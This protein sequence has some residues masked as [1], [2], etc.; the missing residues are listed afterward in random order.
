[1]DWKFVTQN[2]LY[3]IPAIL[4]FTVLIGG[5]KTYP[6]DWDYHLSGNTFGDGALDAYPPLS[7]IITSFALKA[8]LIVQYCIFLF[9]VIPYIL[10]YKT[11][12]SSLAPVAYLYACGIPYVLVWGGFFAQAWIHILML[13]NLISPIFWIPTLIAGVGFHREAFGALG[14]SIIVY[15]FRGWWN[16]TR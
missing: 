11:T 13:L 10:L 6:A 5:A 8:D 4:I 3:L 16:G 12:G 9:L 2:T 14:L 15:F 7:P 1:V